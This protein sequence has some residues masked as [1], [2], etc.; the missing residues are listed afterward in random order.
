MNFLVLY[1]AQLYYGLQS[2]IKR[3]TNMTVKEKCR[4][5]KEYAMALV[6]LD[7]VRN[8]NPIDLTAFIPAYEKV[9]ALRTKCVANG[10]TI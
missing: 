3:G 7:K 2:D 10:V 5:W 4:L 9:E 1:K 6:N 8:K